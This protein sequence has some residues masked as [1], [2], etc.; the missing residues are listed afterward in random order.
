MNSRTRIAFTLI[1][2]L[3]VMTVGMSIFVVSIGMIQRTMKIA[4]TNRARIDRVLTIDRLVREFRFDAHR[5]SSFTIDGGVE[6]TL[7]DGSSIRYGFESNAVIRTHAEESDLIASEQFGLSEDSVALFESQPQSN[8][9]RLTI[10][11]RTSRPRVE[12]HVVAEVGRWI[13]NASQTSAE[14]EET[15]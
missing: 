7:I 15:P 13:A 8:Q 12:R 3:V 9:V 1:E 2:L 11:T 5:S 10:Q 6:F 4:S 14:E